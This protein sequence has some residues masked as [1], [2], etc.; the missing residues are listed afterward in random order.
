MEPAAA[1]GENKGRGAK[2]RVEAGERSAI[3]FVHTV[4]VH[5][6]QCDCFVFSWLLFPLTSLRRGRHE[7]EPRVACQR[8]EGGRRL[9][10]QQRAREQLLQRVW[11]PPLA[12]QRVGVCRLQRLVCRLCECWSVAAGRWSLVAARCAAFAAAETAV[13]SSARRAVTDRPKQTHTH[14]GGAA[15]GRHSH[16]TR[17]G[18]TP[19][20]HTDGHCDRTQPQPPPPSIQRPRAR[21]Q[22]KFTVRRG[23]AANAIG[24]VPHPSKS[25]SWR[26]VRG[27]QDQRADGGAAGERGGV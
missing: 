7:R 6:Y 15:K 20:Q 25:P 27:C 18:S 11:C 10:R 13:S 8:G 9:G 26:S 5:Q 22:Q 12:Q 19:S 14:A 1:R 23:A 4:P 24:H 16:H 17:T 2:L 3:A 21:S